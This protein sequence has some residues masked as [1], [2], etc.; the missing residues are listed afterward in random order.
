MKLFLMKHR[1]ALLRI[2]MLSGLFTVCCALCACAGA[3]VWLEDAINLVPILVAGATSIVSLIAAFT[4]NAVAADVLAEISTWS[5]KVEAGLKNL[6]SLVQQ[7]KATPGESLL[8]EIEDVANLAVSDIGAF[9]QIIGVPTALSAKIQSLAQLLLSQVE[10]LLSLIPAIKAATAAATASSPTPIPAFVAPM[11][12]NIYK[13]QHNA[14][15]NVVSGDDPTDAA[16]SV[17]KQL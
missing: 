13:A 11:A 2:S 12:A 9:N 6:E 10:A 7:Y 3:N 15:L 8:A 17:A 16:A 5:N 14:I 1:I 4:G